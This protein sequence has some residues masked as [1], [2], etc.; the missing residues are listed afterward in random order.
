MVSCDV[1]HSTPRPGNCENSSGQRRNENNDRHNGQRRRRPY[2][3]TSNPQ[4]RVVNKYI[5][6]HLHCPHR[7]NFLVPRRGPLIGTY[8][9]GIFPSYR[10][11]VA[12]NHAS[13]LPS[14]RASMSRLYADFDLHPLAAVT[15]TTM[16][17]SSKRKQ[18][19]PVPRIRNL[20]VCG[21]PRCSFDI[22]APQSI[23]TDVLIFLASPP[24]D[25]ASTPS[26]SKNPVVLCDSSRSQLQGQRPL[27]RRL[28]APANLVPRACER[29]RN[30]A[31]T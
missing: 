26:H 16:Q 15:K 12:S 11:S 3:D 28:A 23:S 29:R 5:A 17:T 20:P 18:C 24:C 30:A 14:P 22:P 9:L 6:Q 2:L 4:V 13:W 1:N 8:F 21:H 27:G 31:T 25:G 10:P 19:Q 7:N